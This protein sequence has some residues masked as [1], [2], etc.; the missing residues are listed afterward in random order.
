MSTF[1]ELQNAVIDTTQRID[2]LAEIKRQINSV[3]KMISLSGRWYP[4]IQEVTLGVLD[5]INPAVFIQAIS[6]P[7]N[8][9]FPIYL[10]YPIAYSNCPIRLIDIETLL[11]P[12][13][14]SADNIA[15]VAGTALHVKNRTLTDTLDMGAYFRPAAL[16]QDTDHNWITDQLDDVIVELSSAFVKTITGDQTTAD[17]ISQLAGSKLGAY[18]ADIV[19]T[20][21][22]GVQ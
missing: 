6:L 17:R 18:L 13:Y 20:H 3:V 16:V 2:K 22:A 4:D 7:A 10:K 12:D 19:M 1:L 21:I 11:H 5:G 8:F 15:Y 14:R 9:R